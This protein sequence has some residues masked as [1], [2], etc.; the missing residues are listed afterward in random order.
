METVGTDRDP[1]LAY[2]ARANLAL[3]RGLLGFDERALLRRVSED[4][5]AAGVLFVEA[6]S[7]M[8]AAILADAAGDTTDAVTLLEGCLPRQLELGHINLIAQELCPRPELAS[9][10]LRRNKSNGL[11]PALI[12]AL[13]HHWRFPEVAPT[14][15]E[16]C[17]S[18]VRTWI[19]HVR[20]G[21][22]PA[23]TRGDGPAKA[24]RPAPAPTSARGPSALDALTPREREVL[25]LMAE[26][27]SNEE[28]AGDL[29]ISIPTVKTHVTHILR[30]LGQKKRMGAVL[31]YQ[32]LSGPTSRGP[33][34]Q[35]T[36]HLHPPA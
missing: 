24:S 1:Y 6:K 14:L 27:R 10:I 2:N 36:T 34:R 13:S 7:L 28:I 8:F 25:Q 15:T 3:A 35:D 19:D 32:R 23:E 18:P 33:D 30:K 4:A 9:L 5:S 31:E 26:E 17:P 16:L 20:T 22:S 12:E 29:F 11:G 21:R